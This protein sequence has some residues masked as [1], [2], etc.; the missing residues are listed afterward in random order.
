M[1][2]AEGVSARVVYKAYATGVI[3]SN[4]QPV[5]ATDPAITGGQILRRVASSIALNK[6]T[7]QSN[8]IRSDRQIADFRHGIKR[9][10]GSISGELSPLTYFDLIEAACRATRGSVVSLS[11]TDFTSIAADLTT[12]TFTATA[13][14]PVALGLRVGHILRF[15]N[16]SDADNNA[17]NF[18]ITGFSGTS[19]RVIGVY[20]APDT[21]AADSA[22]TVT[23]TGKTVFPPLTSH[24]SRKFA[25]EVYHSDIDLAN[26]YTECR[27]GGVNF[28]LPATGLATVEI[29]V[30]GR[31]M[32]IYPAGATAPFFTGPTAATTTGI[33]AAV[34]GV[35]YVAGTRVGV[36]TGITISMNLN[37]SS[38]AVV[39]QNFVPEI[40]L[41]RCTVTGQFTAFLEDATFLNLF[42]NET[43]AT[44]I[45]Y[46]TTTS[47][48]N[49]PAMSIVLPRIK[50]G[51][52]PVGVQGEGGQSIS[53][54]FQALLQQTA[55]TTT[56]LE[57]TTIYFA[58]T[59]IV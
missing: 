2:I 18:L 4:T 30:M 5:S 58:D 49:S 47:A 45:M 19:Q 40:F 29:P 20:P 44:I 15:A 28:G 51:T 14:D 59:E 54:S 1:T 57:P 48:V 17:R 55:V 9:V 22:F 23:T 8:E 46:L 6:D 27:I 10:S 33:F 56:G 25:F 53:C 35:I 16:L 7:Y 3:T 36:V 38:D 37:P 11:N 12:S 50:V 34:N 43:E 21:M 32:E 41:G 39:G 26:L 42:K 31:D 13:G 52:A 24:V